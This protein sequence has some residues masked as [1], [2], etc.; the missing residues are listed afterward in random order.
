MAT[1][2]A[3]TLAPIPSLRSPVVDTTGTLD[4]QQVAGLER[5]A[6]A[7]Q[8]RKGAQLQVLIVPSTQPETI[9]QYTQR[10]FDQWRLGR[11]GI[12]DGVLVLVA[13]DDRRVRI[14]PGYGLDA[15]P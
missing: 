9:E 7:L 10:V 8:Q 6:L 14:Q 15:H 13:K 11:K 12:D 3:Q 5:Q 1:A 2:G 4:A